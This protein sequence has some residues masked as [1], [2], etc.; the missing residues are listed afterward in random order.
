[1][2]FQRKKVAA[3]LAYVA[4]AGGAL[5]LSAAFAQAVNPDVPS[6]TRPDIKVEVTG[7]SIRRV[8]A[9]TA[10]PITVI[11]KD[12][13][14]K[15]GAVNTEQLLATVSAINTMNATQ[16]A[17][18]A[19][20][21]TYGQSSISM[22]GLGS[23]RTLVL[24]NGRRLAP[25]AGDDGASVNINS[26]PIA[27]IER[28]EVL[29]DGA[30]AVYGSDA[31]AG[32]VNFILTKDYRGAEAGIQYGGPTR[33]GG[34]QSTEVHAVVGF[35]SLDKDRYNVTIGASWQKERALFAKDRSFATT[36]NVPGYLVSG[37]TGQGNIEG[38]YQPG[39]GSAAA[40]TWVEGHPIQP[41]GTSPGSGL[42]N[43]LAAT[44]QCGQINMFL[45]PTNTTRGAPFCA[46]DSAHFVGLLP[47]REAANFSGNFAWQLTNSIQFFADGL[48][49]EQKVKQE[50]QS[51]PARRSFFQTDAEFQNQ[52][53]D[54]ALLIF[55]NNPNYALA[56][57]YLTAH[58]FAGSV[59]Q[60]LAIT[61]RVFDFGNRTSDDKATQWRAVAGFRGTWADQ[62]WEAAYTHN[63]NKVEGRVVAGYWSQ[64]GYARL[65]QQSNDWN[66]W[67]LVQTDRFNAQLPSVA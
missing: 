61:A 31:I 37:A 26:I 7:T 67:S 65:I 25:F 27:A 60:P 14:A 36:G 19:G 34:G 2:S 10:L 24:V 64:V 62:D 43:P 9:E 47:D 48:Y 29:R 8:E 55:P 52:G 6:L 50:I 51:S 33:D 16:L 4:G 20:L 28:I 54:P 5:S 59:G 17:T 49:A 32:V 41:F 23:F 46:F 39:T 42:G 22:R 35:G 3:A 11:S 12:E 45:N 56:A 63:E 1:M 15:I 58:G 44:N 57:N 30:S 40:G 13:I 21:S 53:V 38:A 66:P 18:G